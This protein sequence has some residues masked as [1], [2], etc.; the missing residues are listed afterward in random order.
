MAAGILV[1][2]CGN[3]QGSTGCSKVAK[4]DCESV[5]AFQVSAGWILLAHKPAQWK[6]AS[7]WATWCL[8]VSCEQ[9]CG[10]SAIWNFR[11]ADLRSGGQMPDFNH[12]QDVK[13]VAD[14]GTCSGS[15]LI[16]KLLMFLDPKLQRQFN[17]IANDLYAV[18][19]YSNISDLC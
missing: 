11:G 9:L 17:L 14:D 12:N 19:A 8:G 4:Q 7:L 10:T 13:A 3:G 1:D 18:G 16:L 2:R 15:L 5:S 6:I